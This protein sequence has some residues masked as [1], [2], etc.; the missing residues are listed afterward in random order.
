MASLKQR[1]IA[2]ALASALA[3]GEEGLRHYAYYDPPGILT[4]CEGHTGPDV[5]K[6]RF[7]PIEECKKLLSTD[8]NKALDAVEHCVPGLPPQML[9]AWGDAVFNLGS[10]IVCDTKHS[11]AARML[12]DPDQWLAACA[13]LPRWNQAKVAGFMVALPGLTT[14]RAK[15]RALCESTL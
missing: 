1:A 2:L 5:I 6:G 15:D 12:R 14:R 13:Q 4:V 8:M 11:T 9:A 10:K 3:S 7:Y